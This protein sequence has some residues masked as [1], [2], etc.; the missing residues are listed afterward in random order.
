MA[1]NSSDDPQVVY[2]EVTND[3]ESMAEQFIA[4]ELPRFFLDQI[5]LDNPMGLAQFLFAVVTRPGRASLEK[6]EILRFVDRNRKFLSGK[7]GEK[8]LRHIREAAEEAEK[9]EGDGAS[10]GKFLDYLYEHLRHA[11]DG[12]PERID[13]KSDRLLWLVYSC[14]LSAD[15]D[16]ISYKK[17]VEILRKPEHRQRISTLT[18]MFMLHDYAG[19]IG[20]ASQPSPL[21]LMLIAECGMIGDIPPAVTTAIQFLAMMPAPADA[22]QLRDLVTRAKRWL[23]ERNMQRDEI[24]AFDQRLRARFDRVSDDD[25]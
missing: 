13:V 18:L 2:T 21:Y 4:T 22:A 11:I 9:E 7:D 3:P 23:A 12:H 5:D 19:T 6:D 17:A 25:L 24:D 20:E 10:V 1:D 15:S 8:V 16:K 14:A